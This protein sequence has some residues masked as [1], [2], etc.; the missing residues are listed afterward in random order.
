MGI[1]REEDIQFWYMSKN[2]QKREAEMEGRQQGEQRKL[3]QTVVHMKT[4]SCVIVFATYCS[5]SEGLFVVRVNNV[6]WSK[7]FVSFFPY[8]FRHTLKCI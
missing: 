5:Y 3:I 6:S 7:M 2:L 4:L 8:F 1:V